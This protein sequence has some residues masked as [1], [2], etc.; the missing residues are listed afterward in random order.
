[1]MYRT[2]HAGGHLVPELRA[3]R[4]QD[5]G[6]LVGSVADLLAAPAGYRDVPATRH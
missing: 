2:V 3:K 5:L 1:M 4:Y 6:S